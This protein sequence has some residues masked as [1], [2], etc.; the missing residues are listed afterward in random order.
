MAELKGPGIPTEVYIAQ[1]L[2]RM[3]DLAVRIPTDGRIEIQESPDTD[4]AMAAFDAGGA[5]IFSITETPGFVLSV[6][7]FW[8]MKREAGGEPTIH[9]WWRDRWPEGRLR[10]LSDP[11][12]AADS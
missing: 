8:A 3:Q 1:A 7:D 4:F 11:P 9:R 6:A 12:T 5:E 2:P 10:P